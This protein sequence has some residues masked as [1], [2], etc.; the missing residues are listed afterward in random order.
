MTDKPELTVDPTLIPHPGTGIYVRAK[1]PD[2]NWV[3]S[4]I[5]E[6]D[7]ASL[8]T[9]LRS[10]GGENEW[11]ESVVFMLLGHGPFLDAEDADHE[12]G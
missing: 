3:D 4:D 11:A 9:W 6:L 7:K 8:H 2:G 12:N 5:S 10:R 1:N